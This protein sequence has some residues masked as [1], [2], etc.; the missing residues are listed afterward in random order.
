MRVGDGNSS[1]KCTSCNPR[2]FFTYRG[3]KQHLRI[4]LIKNQEKLLSLVVNQMVH[5][6][7]RPK[8]QIGAKT[9]L[10][11]QIMSYRGKNV[12]E[13]PNMMHRNT[14]FLR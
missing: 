13:V 7:A 11:N 9:M 4:C 2:I 12:G 5:K 8:K 14:F 10:K 6:Q 1:L 3:L